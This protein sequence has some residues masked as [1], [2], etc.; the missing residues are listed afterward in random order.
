MAVKPIPKG[1]HSITPYFVVSDADRFIEFVRT[2]FDG[3]EAFRANMPDG[4][5]MHAEMQVGD[6]K[7]MLG[8]ASEQWK[9]ATCSLYVYVED[10][11]RM[12][13]QALQ[14]G[15]TSIMEPKDEFYG[16]RG[17]GI[18]DPFGNQWWIATHKEDVSAEELQRR[19][20][21]RMKQPTSR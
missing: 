10:V 5:V 6:S 16:D 14:A 15:G 9:P 21:E 12:Y 1:Y 20:Q 4:S 7:I 8:Q 17:G 11:D 13:R 18:R 3:K 19:I 2:A